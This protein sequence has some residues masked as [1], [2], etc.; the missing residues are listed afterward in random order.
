MSETWYWWKK[1][2]KYR[3][4]VFFFQISKYLLAEQ[5]EQRRIIKEQDAKLKELYGEDISLL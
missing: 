4:G 3:L 5:I 2:T 1:T